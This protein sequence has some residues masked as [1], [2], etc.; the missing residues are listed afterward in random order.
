MIEI[1]TRTISGNSGSMNCYGKTVY[2]LKL[3]L[4]PCIATE[5]YFLN[6]MCHFEQANNSL[7]CITGFVNT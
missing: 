2:W 5:E 6:K 3:K 4:H 1:K 7:A